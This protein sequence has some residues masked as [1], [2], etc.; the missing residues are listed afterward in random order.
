M[1]QRPYRLLRFLALLGWR[2][3]L[4]HRLHEDKVRERAHFVAGSLGL[5]LEEADIA[6][7]IKAAEVLRRRRRNAG[8][9]EEIVPPCAPEEAVMSGSV[10]IGRVTGGKGW[11]DQPGVGDSRNLSGLQRWRQDNQGVWQSVEAEDERRTL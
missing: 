4:E 8:L 2:G 6:E 10:S 9:S 5:R 1:K 11:L 3:P 7:A